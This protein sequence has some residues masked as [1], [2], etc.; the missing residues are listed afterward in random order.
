MET[1]CHEVVDQCSILTL[2]NFVIARSETFPL[3]NH[4][5]GSIVMNPGDLL[6]Q[7]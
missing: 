2:A 7:L 4:K 5:A 1:V 3:E 6:Q